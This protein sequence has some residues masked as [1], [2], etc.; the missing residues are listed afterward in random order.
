M[1]G[2][3]Q[4]PRCKGD[5][6]TRDESL[7]CSCGFSFRLREGVN[8]FIGQSAAEPLGYDEEYYNSRFYD[9]SE[10]R[11]S[12]VV[13]LARIR[14][15]DRILDLGCGPGAIAVRCALLEAQ[16]FG[17]DPSRAA[18]RLSMKRAQK[19]GV[20]LQL[21][22]FDGKVLPFRDLSFDTIIMADVAEHIDDESMRYLL[23]ECSRLLL[24]GGR[25]V[26]HT[27]PALE[28]IRICRLLRS[29]SLGAADLL[30]GLITPEYEHLHIRY[31]SK[32]SIR[33]L[34]RQSGLSP[35]VWG[36]VRYLMDRWPKQVQNA[37]GQLLADQIWALAFKGPQPAITFPEAP[38]LDF[39][40]IP[41][42][43]DMGCCVEWALGSGFYGREGG[44]RWTEKKAV[45][46]LRSNGGCSRLTMQISSPH[47]DIEREPLKLYV[48]LE[49]KKVATFKLTDSGLRTISIDLSGLIHPGLHEVWLEVDRTFIPE[50]WKINQ[51]LRRLGI[52]VYKVGVE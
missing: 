25:L 52:V 42:N 10:D 19:A 34:L 3:L 47:P 29:F 50:Q 36:E 28:A 26:I 33:S 30:A 20:P 5:L 15:G 35:I 24:P 4:C 41:S 2:L 37:L 38:Y 7:C 9:C 1:T 51:D 32:A 46:Y 48:Y 22:E 27:A 43:L 6:D 14:P 39:I 11:I 45:L 18:L 23:E 12:R 40:D 31:H 13:S 16:A 17:V 49:R 8:E 21:F 44:F